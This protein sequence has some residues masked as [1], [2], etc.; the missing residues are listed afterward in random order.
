MTWHLHNKFDFRIITSSMIGQYLAFR[1]WATHTH[2]KT[3]MLVPTI[4]HVVIYGL[5][6]Y[7][8]NMHQ[9]FLKPSCTKL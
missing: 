4:V 7:N 3:P 6:M 5:N 8:R 9:S 1:E 2:V